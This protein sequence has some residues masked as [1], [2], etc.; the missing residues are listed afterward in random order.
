MNIENLDMKI[1]L[2]GKCEVILKTS[3]KYN[4]YCLIRLG[5]LQLELNERNAR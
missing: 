4:E 3:D 1:T 5:R 2:D